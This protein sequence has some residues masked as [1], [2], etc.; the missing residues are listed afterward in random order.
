MWYE[1]TEN[2]DQFALSF[3][4]ERVIGCLL[5]GAVGDAIGAA[6][7]CMPLSQI[8][9]EF[10]QAGIRRPIAMHSGLVPIS[11]NTQMSIF[12]ADGLLRALSQGPELEDDTPA[13]IL[14]RSYLRWFYTQELIFPGSWYWMEL[15]GWLD[16]CPA[17]FARRTVATPSLLALSSGR[18]GSVWDPINAC[19]EC[20]AV[21]RVAPVGV[22]A[23]VAE[24]FA[25]AADA[26]AITH[27]SPSAYLSA[28]VLASIIHCLMKGV[29]LQEAVIR[30]TDLLRPFAGHE[31]VLTPL[32]RA[33]DLARRTHPSAEVVESLGRGYAAEEALAIGIYCAMAYADDFASGVCL[34]A[35][36]SGDSD[37]TASITG[38]LLGAMLGRDGIPA[39]WMER[40]ELRNQI[41][42]LAR[43]LASGPAEDAEW[44]RR[45]PGW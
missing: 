24:P 37:A 31:E 22:A 36:H 40:I 5:G 35:N 42:C 29:D 44:K 43:D 28:G 6:V 32:Q 8:R 18:M 1:Y 45:Y 16:E 27:G 11:G 9:R 33:V 23:C 41:E 19:K 17:L 13:Q 2:Q 25:V 14:H 3:D 34:A 30:T 15:D 38:Y 26:A 10:G 4:L 20:G 12:T 39:A 7:D 21:V